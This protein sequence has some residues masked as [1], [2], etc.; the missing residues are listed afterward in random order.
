[1]GCVISF[2]EVGDLNGSVV[3]CCVGMGLMRYIMVFYDE[4]VLIFKF[5]LII[6]DCFGVGDS[7]LY[8]EGIVIFLGWFGMLFFIIF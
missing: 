1:M 4:L 2:S 6:L 7:E 5:W 3:F 8:V